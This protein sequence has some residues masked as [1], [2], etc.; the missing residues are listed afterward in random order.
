MSSILK[1]THADY[2]AEGL[3]AADCPV[4]V[5]LESTIELF[6]DG[7]DRNIHRDLTRELN[8]PLEV[9][10]TRKVPVAG[11]VN[12]VYRTSCKVALTAPDADGVMHKEIHDYSTS[13]PVAL[14]ITNRKIARAIIR[15]A[16]SDADLMA[17]ENT[18]LVGQFGDGT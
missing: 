13:H 17:A 6:T 10:T 18:Q 5:G 7:E 2:L 3:D 16:M 11:T 1:V 14:S 12:G 8:Q 4:G 15:K 9:V